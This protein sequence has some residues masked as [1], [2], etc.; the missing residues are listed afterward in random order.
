MQEP[1]VKDVRVMIAEIISAGKTIYYISKLMR[2]RV[3]QVKRMSLNGRCQPY[4]YEML[5]L[6]HADTLKVPEQT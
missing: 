3:E 1:D 6:I 5:K 4:E 2:R